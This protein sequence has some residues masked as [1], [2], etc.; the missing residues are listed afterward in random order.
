VRTDAF[1]MVF[2]FFWPLASQER[3]QAVAGHDRD[4]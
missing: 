1:T 4:A 3:I 2:S